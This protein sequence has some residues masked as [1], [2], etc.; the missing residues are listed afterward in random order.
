MAKPM[1]VDSENT[2][3]GYSL[4]LWAASSWRHRVLGATIE[5]AAQPPV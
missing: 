3:G 2:L 5:W 4:S 1:S